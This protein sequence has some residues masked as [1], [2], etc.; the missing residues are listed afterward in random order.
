[1]AHF[2]LSGVVVTFPTHPLS[3]RGVR[4]QVLDFEG[5]GVGALDWRS[6]V[7]TRRRLGT[8]I[9]STL[10]RMSRR[11]TP[12]QSE[13]P[14]PASARRARAV[15]IGRLLVD[16]VT[17]AEAL[18]AVEALV[19]AGDGGTVVTPN[20]DHVVTAEDNAAF[21][22]ALARASL[23]LADGM[24]LLWVSRWF[25]T[26][27]PEKISGSDFTPPVL[28][29]AAE[30]GLRV[31][32]FGGADGSADAARTALAQHL[33]QLCVVGVLSPQVNMSDPASVHFALADAI[34]ATKPD[35]VVLGLGS[36][37]QELFA[38]R[39]RHRLAPAV[40]L[41]VGA[42][43]DFLAGRVPRAPTWMSNNGLEW[44][45][46]LHKEPRRLYRRY[47]FRGPKFIGIVIRQLRHTRRASN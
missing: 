15:R 20:V 27:L 45:Y 44:L 8:V 1:M 41:S 28:Q 42:T 47:L 13:N 24:P 46:R 43:I 3:A 34:A 30:R 9:D 4:A 33:P 6:S 36:P 18:D 21:S 26:P 7:A 22:D 40:L 23:A 5:V 14:E 17:F 39:V 2:L 12:E 35:L 38:E 10:R 25:G 37:K 31:F 32:L 16:R 11:R 29:R 19:A